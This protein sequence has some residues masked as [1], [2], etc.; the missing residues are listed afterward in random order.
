[1]SNENKRKYEK[2]S[3]HSYQRHSSHHHHSSRRHSHYSKEEEISSRMERAGKN[4]IYDN[5][6]KEKIYLAFKRTSF[7]II[8]LALIA[9]LIFSLLRNPDTDKEF[10]IFDNY[11]SEEEIIE[12]KNKIIKYEYYIEELE[13]RLSKYEE[14]E[15]IN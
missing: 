6:R 3:N 11:T 2:N 13:E 7:C 9:F 1:M 10:K 15:G 14:V 12:L 8:F 5:V 4:I